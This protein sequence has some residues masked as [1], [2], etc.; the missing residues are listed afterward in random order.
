[1]KNKIISHILSS[2][3]IPIVVQTENN[4]VFLQGV[5]VEVPGIPGMT[6]EMSN[7]FDH[8]FYRESDGSILFLFGYAYNAEEH[9]IIFDRDL[10][11]TP[12]PAGL[13]TW[14]PGDGAD[15]SVNSGV[16]I[17][18]AGR[19]GFTIDR[20]NVN[21]LHVDQLAPE[22]FIYGMSGYIGLAQ[23]LSNNSFIMCKINKIE[24]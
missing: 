1:M 21:F 22:C 4:P 23:E 6:I 11:L 16:N 13:T 24:E 2:V 8:Y 15:I 19:H 18:N 5:T 3:N 7:V 9:Y 14:A 17:D 10:T 12:I 20:V